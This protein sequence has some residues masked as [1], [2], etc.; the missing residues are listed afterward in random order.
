MTLFCQCSRATGDQGNSQTL[1]EKSIAIQNMSGQ[2]CDRVVQDDR[3]LNELGRFVKI[4][5][6]FR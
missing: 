1:T 4:E 5:H 3:G 2:G 6:T